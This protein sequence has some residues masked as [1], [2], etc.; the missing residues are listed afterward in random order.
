VIRIAISVE[1]FGAINDAAT[2]ERGENY[3]G[4][5]LRLAVSA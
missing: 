1:A 2:N 4:V 3:S 5:I